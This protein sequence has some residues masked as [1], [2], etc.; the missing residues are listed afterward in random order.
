MTYRSDRRQMP[1]SMLDR[2]GRALDPHEAAM[3]DLA[4]NFFM[5]RSDAKRQINVLL[6]SP[7][8]RSLVSGAL[9]KYLLAS[10]NGDP[11]QDYQVSLVA[12]WL[13]GQD[14]SD[15]VADARRVPGVETSAQ[16]M[17]LVKTFDASR[18]VHAE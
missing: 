18:P 7:E 10:D 9:A 8:G 1:M 17:T 13:A 3:T 14:A 5:F 2:S 6:Q 15:I 12:K 11:D 4:K 16:F